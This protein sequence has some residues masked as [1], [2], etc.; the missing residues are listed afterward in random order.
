MKIKMN[1]TAAGPNGT[2]TEGQTYSAPE[3]ISFIEAMNFISGG[4][5]TN[6]GR[7]IETAAVA[8]QE[9]AVIVKVRKTRKAVEFPTLSE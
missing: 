7:T 3:E 8:P 4:Y 1:T 9:S 6:M 2:Y 5:A